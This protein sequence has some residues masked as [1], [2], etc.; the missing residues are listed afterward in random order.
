MENKVNE[1]L[2]HVDK[3]NILL[4]NI[5]TQR[6]LDQAR[7]DHILT[8]SG[9]T[10]VKQNIKDETHKLQACYSQRELSDLIDSST[11]K[12]WES[13][14]IDQKKRLTN[15][16]NIINGT[17]NSDTIDRISVLPQQGTNNGILGNSLFNGTSFENK[18]FESLYSPFG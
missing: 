8:I 11:N 2:N 16:A 17:L 1:F 4:K 14:T 9:K 10:F 5:D 18:S 12:I 13:L 7:K 15:L 3:K 6:I